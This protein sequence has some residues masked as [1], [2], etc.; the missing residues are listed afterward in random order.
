MR[1]MQDILKQAQKM[2]RQMLQAQ[3]E[4]EAMVIEGGAAGDLVKVKVNGKGVILSLKINH[5]IVDSQEVEMLEDAVLAAI[6]DAVSKAR[7]AADEKMAQA[8]GG[9]GNISG[10]GPMSKM[11]GF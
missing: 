7:K 10:M 8:A 4:L 6:T 3:E 11:I 2:Q 1:G 5:E 9:I